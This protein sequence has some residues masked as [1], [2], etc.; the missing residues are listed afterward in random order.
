PL[1]SFFTGR[2]RVWNVAFILCATAS[3]LLARAAH[4]FPI[5]YLANLGRRQKITWNMQV[6]IWFSGLRGAIA[7]ALAQNMPGPHKDVYTTTTLCI[8]ILTTFVCG[9]L[10]EPMLETLGMKIKPGTTSC[11][12]LEMPIAHYNESRA[13][14]R[15]E[16]GDDTDA[17][18][19]R[20][21]S[22]NGSYGPGMERPHR[23]I[24]KLW[25]N[26]DTQ[27]MKPVFGGNEEEEEEEEEEIYVCGGREEGRAGGREEKENLLVFST[28]SEQ[29]DEEI[30]ELNESRYKFSKQQQQ[31]QH[32]QEQHQ[33]QQQLRHQQQQQQQRH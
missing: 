28:A 6:A 29:E 19:R 24:H 17:F 12:D 9:G 1:S 30:Q 27:Y 3:C 23:G 11:T 20:R 21:T 5:S 22:T 4:I 15:G 8:C 25:K 31:Q 13:S 7:F 18:P 2:F 33:Q 32:Y 10:T 16:G 14:P 26:F